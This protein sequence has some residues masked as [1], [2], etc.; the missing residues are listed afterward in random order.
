MSNCRI[1][2]V[3]FDFDGTLTDAEAHSKAFFEES[4]E[5]LGSILGLSSEAIR[6]L[7]NEEEAYVRNAG[8]D[9]GWVNEGLVVAPG[10]SDPYLIANSTTARIFCRF[11]PGLGGRVLNEK[12]FDVH[13]YAYSRIAPQFRCDAQRV[14]RDVLQRIPHAF[15]VTNSRTDSVRARLQGCVPDL[16]P[17]LGVYGNA[18]KFVVTATLQ[19]DEQ[20]SCIPEFGFFDGLNRKVWLRRGHYYKVLSSIWT[21]T[22]TRPENTLVCGDNFELDLA[23]PLALGCFAHLVTRPS[24]LAHE[25]NAAKSN[26]RCRI[27]ADLESVLGW[28]DR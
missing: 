27:S 12:V 3:V 8:P 28:L 2:C 10:H 7:W 15:V 14:L 23:M 11:D 25:H 16:M 1:D 26:S 24:T 4:R 13:S 21:E 17:R 22:S 18:Q 9:F 6:Q 19:P 5:R 20:L